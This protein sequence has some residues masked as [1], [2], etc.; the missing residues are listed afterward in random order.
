MTSKMET[1]SLLNQSGKLATHDLHYHYDGSVSADVMRIVF[2]DSKT[3][4]RETVGHAT[5]LVD[6]TLLREPV[7]H[8]QQFFDSFQK[9]LALFELTGSVYPILA[10]QFEA[11]IQEG[12]QH[13]D[14]RFGCGALAARFRLPEEAV[15]AEFKRAVDFAQQAGLDVCPTLCFSRYETM[16]RANRLAEFVLANRDF[17]RA[18]DLEGQEAPNPTE[19]YALIFRELKDAGLR[20]TVHAGEF[21]SSKAIWAAIDGC[22]AERVGHAF[23]AADDPAL[24][25]RLAKDQIPVEVSLTS[26]YL[27]GLCPN[28]NAHPILKM[29]EAGVPIVLCTDDKALFQ[30]SLSKEYEKAAAILSAAGLKP[31]EILEGISR[32]SRRFAFTKAGV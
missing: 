12:I 16:E 28:L 17:I 9:V 3:Q 1:A 26:N 5:L 11:A 2:K 23:T 30:T 31:A 22:G 8:P 14:F 32:N 25:R 15:L 27:L 21:S 18:I 10:A 29:L 19:A 13:L 20:V 7:K 24:L 6:E 4:E